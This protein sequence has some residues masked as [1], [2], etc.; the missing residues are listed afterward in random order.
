[1]A[2]LPVIEVIGR[3]NDVLM[4]QTLGGQTIRLLPLALGTVIEETPGV[5]RFQ[6]IQTEATTT[7]CGCR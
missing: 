4:F 1:M 3:T 5:H 7:P 6:A 2:A